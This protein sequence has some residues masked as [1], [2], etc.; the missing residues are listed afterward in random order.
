MT[1][2]TSGGA[3]RGGNALFYALGAYG[4]WG[5]LPVY[6]FWLRHVSPVELVAA[7]TVFSVP[8]AL[9]MAAG[10]RQLGAVGRALCSIRLI[11]PLCLSAALI[12]GNWLIYIYAIQNGHVLAASLG[13]Y[14]NPLINVLIGTVFLKERL[15][16]RQWWAVALAALAVT[17]LAFGAGEMVWISLSLAISFGL[18]GLVR[19]LARVAAMPGLAVETVL[20]AP[21]ALAGLWWT[22]GSTGDL[23]FGRDGLETTLLIGS[24]LL[25]AIPLFL[26]AEAARRL[27]MALLGFVQ[28]I[29][30]TIVFVLGLTLFRE[31]L[32]PLQIACFA[33]I[34]VAIGIFSHDMLARRHKRA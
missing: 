28:F 33:L 26:F 6:F 9:A 20:L 12:G 11:A 22:T 7:R 18:Y 15:S 23:A 16:R 27:D 25:T 29:S 13:Y 21:L 34:W 19:K 17:L 10:M 32:R 30:P 4:T 1:S 14:I 5:V 31:P 2:S 24:A 3:D 8:L